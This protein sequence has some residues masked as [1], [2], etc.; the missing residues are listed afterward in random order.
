MNVIENEDYS[1]I[2]IIEDNVGDFFLRY[3]ITILEEDND[4]ANAPE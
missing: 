4:N 2:D 1:N 3:S